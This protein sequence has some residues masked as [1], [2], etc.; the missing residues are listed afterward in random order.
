MCELWAALFYTILMGNKTYAEKD[1]ADMQ[2]EAEAR[3]SMTG[4]ELRAPD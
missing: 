2:R 4:M 3:K 1:E